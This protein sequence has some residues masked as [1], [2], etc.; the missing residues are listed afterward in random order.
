M[1]RGPRYSTAPA[2]AGRAARRRGATD[3]SPLLTPPPA[4]DSALPRPPLPPA[5]APLRAP[6][7]TDHLEGPRAL[8][9]EGQIQQR[10]GSALYGIEGREADVL[11]D[12]GRDA[13]GD[14]RRPPRFNLRHCDLL[15]VGAAFFRSRRRSRPRVAHVAC[16]SPRMHPPTHS[17]RVLRRTRRSQQTTR[18]TS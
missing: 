13:G 5:R 18:S 14:V 9:H 2:C 6:L 15:C 4:I 17:E 3:C 8:D 16:V 1:V 10:R 12:V 7:E 11:A